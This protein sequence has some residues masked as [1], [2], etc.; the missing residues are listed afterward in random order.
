MSNIKCQNLVIFSFKIRMKHTFTINKQNIMKNSKYQQFFHCFIAC[1]QGPYAFWFSF[2]QNIATILISTL[3]K[4]ATLIRGRRLF[5]CGYPEHPHRQIVLYQKD[6]RCTGDEVD[7]Q[8]CGA[9]FRPGAY[10]RKHSNAID[11]VSFQPFLNLLK[12]L[13][14]IILTFF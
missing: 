7:T 14:S 6:A 2:Q 4:G 3:F 11:F 9:Y 1:I 8:R 12:I 10:Q 5:Q 13:Y